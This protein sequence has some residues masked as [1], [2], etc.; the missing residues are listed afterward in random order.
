MAFALGG[1]SLWLFAQLPSLPTLALAATCTVVLS[2]FVRH[3]L[4]HAALCALAGLLWGQWSAGRALDL[5]LPHD[6]EGKALVAFGR[7]DDLPSRDRDGVRFRFCPERVMDAGRV[8]KAH[9]CWRLGWY[10]P[11]GRNGADVDSAVDQVP[12]I[13]AGSRWRL[14]VRLKRPRGLVNPGGFDSE[15]KALE[16]RI[17]AVGYV[18][19]AADNDALTGASGIDAIR[20]RIAQRI[21]DA[22]AG[23]PRMSALLRGL[24]VGDRRG[25]EDTDWLA[26]RQTGTTHLF[27]ISGLHVGMIG[28]CVGLLAS[29]VTFMFPRLLRIAPRRTWSLPPALVAAFLYALLAGFEV[30]TQR[31]VAMIAVAGLAVLLRRGA[32]LWQGWCLAVAAVVLIDPLAV[33][34]IGFWLSYLGVAWLILHAQGRGRR[35]WWSSASQAQWAVTLGLMPI[36]IGFFAQTSWLS[37]LVNLVAIPWITFVVV[38]ILLLGVLLIVVMPSAGDSLLQLSAALLAPLMHGMDTVARWPLVAA[39]FP[40]PTA[41]AVAF[42]TLAAAL[43]FLPVSR[44]LRWACLPLAMPLLLPVTRTPPPGSVELQVLDVGQGTSVLVRTQRH[45]LLF[46]AG[47]RF[48][49]GYDLGDAVVVPALRALGVS[50]LDRLIVS[51]A[52]N[53][54]AGGAA[55]VVRELQPADVL[56]GEALPDVA[57]APCR[58]G[59]QWQWD[60]VKFEL[61]HPPARY[62]IDGNDV[63][64]VLKI[65]AVGS[66]ALLTGDAGAVAE[67]RMINLHR[68]A[69]RSDVLLLGHHGSL[70]SSIPE[71]MDAVAPGF[72][73][74]TAGYRN[75]FGHPHPDVMRRLDWRGVDV[76]QTSRS[77]SIRIE[78][79]PDGITHA[80]RR[81]QRRR[82][83]SEP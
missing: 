39:S 11:H 33:L 2:A 27:S 9:G 65:S 24:A 38:P 58:E 47:A 69:L 6:L 36:G 23:Q 14:T 49:N 71:F 8:I 1:C 12:D 4:R 22:L 56:L 18:R 15:R 35:P 26:F 37:P 83:W 67:L 72:A 51:H 81:E 66:S 20:D 76:A 61:L 16:T 50:R 7:V 10:S 68:A 52:D 13:G 64:C 78:L 32:G 45:S 48:P 21:D 30:A 46:D 79:G 17:A 80:G 55:S 3:G 40:E 29:A 53:D 41:V 34:S 82:F 57:G 31:S 28:L 19:A 62:P 73:V 5:R 75:R 44:W 25:F 54:H 77:G 43:C 74:A 63:S 70:T 59:M 60:G 42:A